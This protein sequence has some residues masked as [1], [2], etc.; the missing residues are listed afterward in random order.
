MDTS[1]S[2]SKATSGSPAIRSTRNPL[3]DVYTTNGPGPN[4][5]MSRRRDD[6]L[7]DPSKPVLLH[8]SI[9]DDSVAT[10]ELLREFGFA[11]C[12]ADADRW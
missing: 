6:E 4:R 5:R 9:I 3:T 11:L 2:P 8:E 7:Y 1:R 12:D 10:A